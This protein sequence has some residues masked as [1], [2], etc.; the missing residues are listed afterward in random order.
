MTD[1]TAQMVNRMDTMIMMAPTALFLLMIVKAVI[2]PLEWKK[3]LTVS[4]D[5]KTNKQYRNI[6]T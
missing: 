3:Q 6:W 1:S 5:F 4:V 2:Q